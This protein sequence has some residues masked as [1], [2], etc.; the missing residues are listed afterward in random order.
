MGW[1]AFPPEVAW[2]RAESSSCWRLAQ[3]SPGSLRENRPEKDYGEPNAR[4]RTWW[5]M[6]GLFS[7][8]LSRSLITSMIFFAAVSLL[9]FREFSR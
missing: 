6:I 4:I 1:P 2:T 5:W 9:A 8:S 7:A 3:R